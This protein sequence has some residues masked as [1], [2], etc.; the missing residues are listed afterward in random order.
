[1][2]SGNIIL[3]INCKANVYIGNDKNKLVPNLYKEIPK[4]E[5]A[6]SE[7]DAIIARFCNFR[8]YWNVKYLNDNFDKDFI[9]ETIL[10]LKMCSNSMV[11]FNPKEQYFNQ[12]FRG[13]GDKKEFFTSTMKDICI[14][15]L[16]DIR[17]VL[18]QRDY[19]FTNVDF[20]LY[21][22]NL[23]DKGNLLILDPPYILRSDMYDTDFSQQHDIALIDIIQNTKSDFIYF[24]Y[25]YRDGK[26]NENLKKLIDKNN[27]KVIEINNKTLAGQG[28]SQNIKEVEEVIVTNVRMQ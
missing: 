8:D 25:L 2:G 9:Y 28:R 3:N 5:Y 26:V 14:C 10:L 4:Y 1:M 11:R 17:C 21:E 16:N 7:L 6:I 19:K 12:G 24:N 13:L 15:G 23:L 18:K 20:L 27:F 22:D